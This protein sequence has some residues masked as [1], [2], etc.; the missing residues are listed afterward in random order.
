MPE[1]IPLGW[2]HTILGVAA[3]LSGFYTI[4]KYRVIA[5]EQRSG[6]LY[7]LLTLI[8]AGTALGI[9]NQGGFGIAHILA[10][11]TLAALACGVIMEKTNLFGSASKYFQALGYTSTLLF[12][13][14]PAITD[15]LRRL[16]IGDPFI[17][18]LEDP[19]LQQFHLAFLLIFVI[20]LIAQFIWLK[21]QA[22][23]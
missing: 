11:L 1:M 9:Y 13:M 23:A 10:V 18:T 20:G 16:P 21:K 2:F 5:L 7:A 12:H 22:S 15:F 6:K 17:N 4:I 3:V 14:I 19:L 8:V